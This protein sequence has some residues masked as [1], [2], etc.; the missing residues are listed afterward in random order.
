[1]G[2]P[3]RCATKA[4]ASIAPAAALIVANRFVADAAVVPV[5]AAM[6][7]NATMQISMAFGAG[8]PA[9]ALLG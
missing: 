1:M 9:S 3:D 2:R 8:G 5:L 6:T 4:A 7:A